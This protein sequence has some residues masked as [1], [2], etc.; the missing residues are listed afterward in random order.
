V[1][2]DYLGK[3]VR[4]ILTASQISDIG[5]GGTLIKDQPAEFIVADKGYHS[6]AF[7]EKPQRR[8]AARLSFHLAPTDS[9]HVPSIAIS[10]RTAI[11]SSASFVAS[12]N[13]E[14]SSRLRFRLVGVIEN[15]P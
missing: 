12:S 9:T 8:K 5:Q 13:S 11:W 3:P 14:A 1:T 7:I 10:K 2:V 15:K 4:V 6:D